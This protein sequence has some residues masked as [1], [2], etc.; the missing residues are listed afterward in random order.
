MQMGFNARARERLESFQRLSRIT[1]LSERI[2][3][4]N[5]NAEK[6]LSTQLEELVLYGKDVDGV[7]SFTKISLAL[8]LTPNSGP[9]FFLAQITGA[10]ERVATLF[11]IARDLHMQVVYLMNHLDEA[12]AI[13]GWNAKDAMKLRS[14]LS[15]LCRELEGRA[16]EPERMKTAAAERMRSKLEQV[17]ARH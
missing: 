5:P 3:P 16:G 9:V 6:G 15:V 8:P 13:P 14:D 4:E 17:F 1:N 11:G 2:D 7:R 10:R 12:E